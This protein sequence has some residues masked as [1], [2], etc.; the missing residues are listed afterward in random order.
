MMA[1]KLHLHLKIDEQDCN[2][3]IKIHQKE[4]HIERKKVKEGKW[5]GGG[6]KGK[7]KRNLRDSLV[8]L[9]ASFR[10]FFSR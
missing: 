5:K 1:Q 6:K 3:A 9:P 7:K 4:K 10:S 8:S 2:E